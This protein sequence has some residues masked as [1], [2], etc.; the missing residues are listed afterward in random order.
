MKKAIII[1]SGG[2]DSTGVVLAMALANGRNCHALSF[3]YGQKHL[4]E[5]KAAKKIADFYQ[6][7]HQIIRLDPSAFSAS[8]LVSD[9]KVPQGRSSTQMIQEGIPSTYV[10]ARNTLFLA[11]ALCQCELR[12]ADEIHF[13]PNKLDSP[14]YPDCH[15]SYL[16][17]FQK[18]IDLATKQAVEGSPPQLIIP[19]LN[20]TKKE[21]VREGMLLNAPLEFTWSCY[22]PTAEKHPC[23]QCDACILRLEGF[24]QATK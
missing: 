13:G 2:L 3:D 6:I 1:F 21:I 9:L 14:C 23:L 10:P 4:I 20:L 12:Q 16:S 7:S 11:Y 17:A 8:S 24:E 19:L 18:V 15:P 5:L 22:S